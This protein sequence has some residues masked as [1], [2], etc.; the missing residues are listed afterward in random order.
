MVAVR[1]GSWEGRRSL[2]RSI[3]RRRAAVS[4]TTRAPRAWDPSPPDGLERGQRAGRR[5]RRARAWRRVA[6]TRLRARRA[7]VRPPRSARGTLPGS[8]L[9]PAGAPP[10]R[11]WARRYTSRR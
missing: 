3:A 2:L 4:G 5:L 11:G 1:T 6:V 10:E 7:I 9:A 8:F